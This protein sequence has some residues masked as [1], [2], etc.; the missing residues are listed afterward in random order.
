MERDAELLATALKKARA[1]MIKMAIRSGDF[2]RLPATTKSCQLCQGKKREPW[3]PEVGK[4]PT[5]H[6]CHDGEEAVH[7]L[8]AMFGELP[9]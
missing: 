3:P 5:H 2:D 4:G 6:T 8:E 1:T 9:R 7:L